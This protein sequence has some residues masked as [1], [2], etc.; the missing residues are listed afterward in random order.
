[1]NFNVLFDFTKEVLNLRNE[2]SIFKMN[3]ISE[4]IFDSRLEF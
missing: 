4:P 2:I 1:M 3:I